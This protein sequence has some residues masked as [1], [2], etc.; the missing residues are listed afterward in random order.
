MAVNNSPL[1]LASASKTRLSVLTKAGIAAEVLKP[2]ADEAALQDQWQHLL[3]RSLAIEL[4]KAKALSIS[5]TQPGRLILGADQ[6]LD[7]DGSV[8]HKARNTSEAREKLR[9][10]RGRTHQLHSAL[11]MARDGQIM[12]SHVSTATL[13]MRQFSDA[14][15]EDYL[16]QSGAEALSA[17]GCYFYEGPGIQLFETVEGDVF[18]I[19]GLPLLPL[20]AFLRQQSIIL[21]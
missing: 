15:L 4:A 18:T 20:L 21:S 11:A 7:L 9:A 3:P 16:A 1:I 2:S 10:L 13:T 6:S 12:F 8:L 14:F 19:L 17:V 5:G